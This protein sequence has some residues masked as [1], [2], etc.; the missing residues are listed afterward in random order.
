MKEYAKKVNMLCMDMFD[1]SHPG[2]VIIGENLVYLP[3]T[4]LILIQNFKRRGIN[5]EMV[6][7][8]C[9]SIRYE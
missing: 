9:Y 3:R 5:K 2:L 8:A 4:Q 6:R 7:E 1:P